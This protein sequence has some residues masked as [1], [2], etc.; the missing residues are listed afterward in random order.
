MEHYLVVTAVGTDR[1]G[2]SDE[3][4]RLITLCDCNIVD[5]RLALF[6]QEFTLIMLLSGS[7]NA[8]SRV[9]STLPLKAS[10]HDLLTVMKRTTKHEYRHYAY[11][12]DFQI[13][14]ND[15]PGLIEQFT[16][17]FAS[18]TID[19]ASLSAHTQESEQNSSPNRFQLQIG[20][21]LPEGCNL[22]TLQE[23]FEALC[24]DLVVT[25]NVTFVGHN[26]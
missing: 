20:T 26:Q 16:R 4:T 23:E 11:T 8:I 13:E 7:A 15:S 10:E 3:V 6:G 2:I 18:R 24:Q 25:G 12:A 17:F 21:N 1:P 9:E 19:I 22:M 5:S 14:A